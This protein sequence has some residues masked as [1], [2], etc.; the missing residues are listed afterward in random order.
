MKDN[1]SIYACSFFFQNTGFLP[2]SAIWA[3][4]LCV[5]IMSVI[6][7]RMAGKGEMRALREGGRESS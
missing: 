6:S 3:L 1:K 7:R 2:S 5:V 4:P